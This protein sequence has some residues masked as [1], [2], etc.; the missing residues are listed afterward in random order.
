MNPVNY[1]RGDECMK[2]YQM[3]GR[4]ILSRKRR[5][6]YAALGVVVG[7]MTVTGILTVARAGEEKIYDQLEKYGPNL[8]ATPAIQSMGMQVGDLTLGMLAVGENY[9]AYQTVTDIRNIADGILRISNNITDDREIAVIA[10]KLYINTTI[11]GSTVMVVGIEPE[12]E[13]RVKL[14][15]EVKD[16]QYLEEADQALF[17]AAAASLL[18][19]RTGDK[20]TLGGAELTVSGILDATA[21]SEDYQVFVPLATLQAA[22]DKEGLYS[23]L[24]MRICCST[25]PVEEI[26]DAINAGVPGV[27]ALAVKQ[28]AAS[29]QEMMEKVNRLMMSLSSLTLVVGL[30]GVTNTMVASVNERTKDIGIMRAVGASGGQIMRIFIYEAVIIGLIGGV[31]GYLAGTGLAYILGPSIFA[32]VDVAYVPAYLPLSIAL[33]TVI[34]VASIVYPAL[35]ASRLKVAD[36][37]K[38]L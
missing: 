35:R 9:L 7:T 21:T 28:V 18:Q 22:F 31:L 32:G 16:G 19:V 36:S 27:R 23:A 4:D 11:K 17:G 37:F 15:W 33:A 26:A 1:S 38:S 2:L 10:P 3:V 8:I 25:C 12:A 20:L 29:E 24:D 14:W 30:F 34:A 13:Y 5:I 6:L